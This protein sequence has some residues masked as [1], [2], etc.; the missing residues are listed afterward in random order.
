MK[1][2]L[3]VVASLIKKGEKVLIC[4]RKEDDAFGLLW[5]FPGGRVESGE[6]LQAALRREIKEELGVDIITEK[7]L[8][9]FKDQ[10][11]DLKIT[12]HLFQCKIKEGI[13]RAY[14]CN[15]FK[16][17]D[18]K[19]LEKYNLAPVDKKIATFLKQSHYL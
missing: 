2:H 7:H 15:D 3:N 4:Q 8:A 17:V 12:V 13:L 16:F 6:S 18:A 5:E 14:D 1:P 19:E 9:S 10:T 11:Q